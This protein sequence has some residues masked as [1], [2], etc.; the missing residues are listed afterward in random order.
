MRLQC[1]ILLI[2]V[3][4]AWTQEELPAYRT[5]NLAAVQRLFEQELADYAG[6]TNVMVLPGV[7]AD[8][9]TRQVTLQA[10]ATGLTAHDIAEF[11]IIAPHSGNDYE[12]LSLS[13]AT[14]G[15]VDRALRFIGLTPGLCVDYNAYRFWA[16]G[17]RV[18]ASVRRHGTNTAGQP[19]ESFL[20]DEPTGKPLAPDGLVYVQASTD[21]VRK[22]D[23]PDRHPVDAD[24][25]GS[26]AANYNEPCTLLDVPRAA[27]QS[28]VYSRQ[29]VNP[30]HGFAPGERLEIVLT[31]ELPAG[32]LRV[33]DLH[34][35]VHAAAAATQSLVSLTFALSNST[36][37]SALTGLNMND[38]LES[39]TALRQQR[40]DP[41]VSLHID[42]DVQIDALK[43]FCL[44]LASIE[45]D[46]G[47]RMEP[48]LPGH[49]YY[50]AYMPDESLRDRDQR[51]MQP[52]ELNFVGTTEGSVSVSLLEI[53][54]H[55][56]DE[57]VRPTLTFKTHPIDSPASLR[58]QLS[59]IEDDLPVLL[60][61]APP[62]LTH[63][64]LMHWMLPILDTHP[65]VHVFTSPTML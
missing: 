23:Q 18:T 30:E 8:R 53:I 47:I 1:M 26:I 62:T 49:L 19:I 21:W 57:D 64:A 2:L 60:V 52:A 33:Q 65:T 45:T 46:H 37:R 59:D 50:K 42:P 16:K 25:R 54:E 56:H 24:T 12:A 5:N 35:S 51:I 3:Q 13:F 61:F 36:D 11:Y 7:R 4:T 55:W 15:D 48:P 34:L 31:P 63:G 44:I 20:I 41:F 29:T 6:N 27:P 17:E 40:K 22:T 58:E 43:A 38:F 28:E 32:Q 10:E 39:V 9:T 14:A